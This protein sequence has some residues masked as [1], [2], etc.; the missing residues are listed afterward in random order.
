MGFHLHARVFA[1]GGCSPAA[2]NTD[3][4]VAPLRMVQE[5]NGGQK[6]VFEGPYGSRTLFLIYES[7]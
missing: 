5:H 7:F 3:K 1:P 6:S 4:N 2:C